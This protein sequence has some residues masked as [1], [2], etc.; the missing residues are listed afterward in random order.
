LLFSPLN[1][2]HFLS[3]HIKRE[4]RHGT[5]YLSKKDGYRTAVGYPYRLGMDGML[6][7]GKGKARGAGHK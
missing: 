5:R 1:G 7:K 3:F 4:E 2:K 6:V